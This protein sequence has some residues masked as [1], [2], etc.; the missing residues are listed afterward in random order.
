VNS[1][2]KDK[3]SLYATSLFVAL[4]AVVLVL[5]Y[6]KFNTIVSTM[7][8]LFGIGIAS[9][10]AVK[11]HHAIG[12]I[13]SVGKET[14]ETAKAL[15]LDS[16]I[17]ER[18]KI[19]FKTLDNSE[20]EYKCI[21][22]HKYLDRPLPS[23]NAGDYYALS[24]LDRRL[25]SEKLTLRGLTIDDKL[26]DNDFVGKVIFVCAHISNPAVKQVF[27]VNCIDNDLD[28]SKI[29]PSKTPCWFADDSRTEV[30]LPNDSR[31]HPVRKIR[32]SINGTNDLI[33]S[34]AEESYIKLHSDPNYRCA[35]TGI[36]Q[37]YGILGRITIKQNVY[38]I[39]AGIHQYGTWIVAEFLDRLLTAKKTKFEDPL[40]GN[41]D[42]IGVIWGEF[43]TAKMKVR[44]AR[45]HHNYLW[46]KDS[47]TWARHKDF[48]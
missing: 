26:D 31:E 46:V 24:V 14:K 12:K 23:I 9:F 6:F 45:I 29:D 47:N 42:F 1:E 43:D 2:S 13:H 7:L 37:D 16:L 21:Y 44:D 4:C 32:I 30:R 18:V 17:K 10:I 48:K 27:E 15:R 35:L 40:L 36:Q 25:G 11:Q 5:T 20:D 19:Y 22:P 28:L 39:L 41:E 33:E 3:W 38:F 34:P 8:G